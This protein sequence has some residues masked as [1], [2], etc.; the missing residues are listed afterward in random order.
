MRSRAACATGMTG[1]DPHSARGVTMGAVAGGGQLGEGAAGVAH[2]VIGP[3]PWRRRARYSQNCARSIGL[4]GGSG[5]G[6]PATSSSSVTR[7]TAGHDR[8][9][10]GFRARP[11][12]GATSPRKG[13]ERRQAG[14]N[15]RERC[16]TS[17]TIPSVQN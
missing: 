17:M 8:G 13:A 12:G 7:S 15:P 5:G 2:G 14:T 11:A 9:R 16:V 1:P 4:R 3:A 6:G 10:A